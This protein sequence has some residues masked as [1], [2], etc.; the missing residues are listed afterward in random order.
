MICNTTCML[1][2]L[3]LRYI[4]KSENILKYNKPVQFIG[5]FLCIKHDRMQYFN[6]ETLVLETIG[7]RRTLADTVGMRAKDDS[8][9]VLHINYFTI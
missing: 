9:K 3:Y 8:T 2:T 7:K 1:V 6:R 4:C 5:V